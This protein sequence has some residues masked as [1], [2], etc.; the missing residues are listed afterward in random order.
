M[1]F[2]QIP[3]CW[4][5]LRHFVYLLAINCQV[6][7]WLLKFKIE[8]KSFLVSWYHLIKLPAGLLTENCM[9]IIGFKKLNCSWKFMK[10]YTVNAA[11]GICHIEHLFDYWLEHFLERERILRIRRTQPLL[12]MQSTAVTYFRW[13]IYMDI[14]VISMS[15][16][17]S[18]Q[19]ENELLKITV[20]CVLI[21]VACIFTKFWFRSS[22]FWF[23]LSFSEILN[24]LEFIKIFNVI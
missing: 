10:K 5:R 15:H 17:R 1:K 8:T 3:G 18:F 4:V 13:F 9:V 6:E 19:W 7:R 24:F 16:F 14:W 12:V 22:T 11:E 23:D 20:V 2:F 21:I